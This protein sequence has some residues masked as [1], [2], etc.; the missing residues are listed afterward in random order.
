V[1][2]EIHTGI[3]IDAKVNIDDW[4][5]ILC[6]FLNSLT[7]SEFFTGK[8]SFHLMAAIYGN[9]SLSCHVYSQMNS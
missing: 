1:L 7:K 9:S 6:H 8:L 5:P 4:V 3:A 2:A